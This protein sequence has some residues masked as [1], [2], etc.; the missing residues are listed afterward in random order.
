M[1]RQVERFQNLDDHLQDMEILILLVEGKDMCSVL[2][3]NYTNVRRLFILSLSMKLML[4]TQEHK[5]FWLCSQ[6][7]L[8]KLNQK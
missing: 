1:I 3:V 4:L 8:E 5:D 6:E 2:K 7:I